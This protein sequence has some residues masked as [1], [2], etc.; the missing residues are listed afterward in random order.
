MALW[1]LPMPPGDSGQAD[2]WATASP[3]LSLKSQPIKLLS[4]IPLLP[5]VP[6]GFGHPLGAETEGKE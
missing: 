5:S 6:S 4:G 2:V 1:C 3:S